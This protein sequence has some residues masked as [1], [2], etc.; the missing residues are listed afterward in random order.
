MTVTY[1]S[2]QKVRIDDVNFGGHLGH[3]RLIT[4]LHQARVEMF[5]SMGVSEIDC[6]G[7]HMVMRRIEIKYSHQSF[8]NDQL[9]VEISLD[10]NRACVVLNYIV[11]NLA[12]N[13]KAASATMQMSVI[14][15][16]DQKP[17]SPEVF[18]DALTV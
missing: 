3:D 8:L 2:I 15:H 4:L 7:E 18:F 6:G 16:V 1:T 14:S 13:K 11:I 17:L 12:V 9:Q 10:R 5:A